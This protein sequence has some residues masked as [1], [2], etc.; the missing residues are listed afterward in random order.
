[1]FN[2]CHIVLKLNETRALTLKQSN[3]VSLSKSIVKL[4]P[5]KLKVSLRSDAKSPCLRL[6]MIDVL[7]E[8]F[9]HKFVI[10]NGRSVPNGS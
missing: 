8:L 6:H 3:D 10:I 2:Q 9:C 1:M 5:L 4:G 7:S